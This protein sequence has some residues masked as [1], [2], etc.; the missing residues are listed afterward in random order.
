MDKIKAKVISS[1]IGKF[2][3]DSITIKLEDKITSICFDKSKNIAQF[4]GRDIYLINNNG[5][6]NI[7][8]FVEE[9]QVIKK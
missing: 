7:E 8:L 6:Y 2:D 5:V 1:E 3:V 9:K 4:D